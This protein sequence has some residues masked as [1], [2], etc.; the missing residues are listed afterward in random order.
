MKT[1]HDQRA[2]RAHLNILSFLTLVV[3]TAQQRKPYTLHDMTNR[4][5]KCNCMSLTS[6]KKHNRSSTPY[7]VTSN[8]TARNHFE[9]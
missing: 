6:N 3:E 2:A 8:T 5:E 7:D 4:K 9:H 1:V